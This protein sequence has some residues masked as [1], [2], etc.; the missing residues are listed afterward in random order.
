MKFV[1]NCCVTVLLSISA[2]TWIKGLISF[3]VNSKDIL[4]S[5]VFLVI[6]G[7]GDKTSCLNNFTS[8][9]VAPG[10]WSHVTSTDSLYTLMIRPIIIS[11]KKLLHNIYK[12]LLCFIQ[13][14]LQMDIIVGES[15]C[16]LHPTKLNIN[17][18]VLLDL[19]PSVQFKKH[20]KHPWRSV[21]FA[22]NFTKGNTPPWLF[23]TFFYLLKW[24]EIVQRVTYVLYLLSYFYL[25]N[26]IRERIKLNLLDLAW[27]RHF[28]KSS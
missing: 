26:S 13:V 25:G 4:F 23:F 14:T 19:V 15:F 11:E 9:S 20:E 1:W 5:R 7:I 17:C 27:K 3:S 2:K 22:C 21:T 12:Q 28:L 24:Y 6:S 18:Y 8:Y 16:Q 10:K